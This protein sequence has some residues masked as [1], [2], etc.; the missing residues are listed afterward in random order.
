MQRRQETEHRRQ[1][2]EGRGQRT[3]DRG[4]S[5]EREQSV[6]NEKCRLIRAKNNDHFECIMQNKANLRKGQMSVSPYNTKVYENVCICRLPKN[7]PNQ[8]QFL[9]SPNDGL[10]FL[11]PIRV[12]DK[13]QQESR[14][15]DG[16]G[17]RIK[18]GMTGGIKHN[19]LPM[20]LF[21]LTSSTAR[22]YNEVFCLMSCLER[23]PNERVWK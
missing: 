1:R 4:Q 2:T 7:K 3:D 9:E 12:R 5:R 10:S 14:L 21:P 13:L 11:P 15:F 6:V 20:A 8:S 18:C 19:Y 16:P 23:T 22:D 17:F